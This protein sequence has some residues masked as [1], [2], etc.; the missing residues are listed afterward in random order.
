VLGQ[1]IGGAHAL[2]T[3][4]RINRLVILAREPS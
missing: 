2:L 4:R 1:L 3:G